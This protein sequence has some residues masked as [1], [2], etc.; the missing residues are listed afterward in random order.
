MLVCT[1]L[2]LCHA[3]VLFS[4]LHSQFAEIAKDERWTSL[5]MDIMFSTDPQ[6]QQPHGKKNLTI[7]ILSIIETVAMNNQQI[8]YNLLRNP[9]YQINHQ[10]K[11]AGKHITA[12]KR[13]ITFQFGFSSAKAIASGQSGANC[14]GEEHEVVLIWSHVSGKRELYMDGRP[15]H[16]S[17][18]ARGN[19]KFQYTWGIGPHVLKIVANFKDQAKIFERQFDLFLDG[20][21]F[22]RFLKIYQLGRSSSNAS[23]RSNYSHEPSTEY[24][25]RGAAY[26]EDELISTSQGEVTSVPNEVNFIPVD[27]FDQPSVATIS[28]VSSGTT[29]SDDES[30]PK[31]YSFLSNAILSAY[32]QPPSNAPQGFFNQVPSHGNNA[33]ALVPVIANQSFSHCGM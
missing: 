18:G 6:H 17:K 16:M 30:S 7:I 19:T 32:S 12:T 9:P 27:L 15:I 31:S 1:Y 14:R 3:S 24:S 23:T 5:S 28:V 22:F 10:S 26:K 11:L 29:L 20:I 33:R 4:S 21:T 2:Y 8:R 25:Y 13:R